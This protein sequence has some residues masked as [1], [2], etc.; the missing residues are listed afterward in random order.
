MEITKNLWHQALSLEQE[1]ERRGEGISWRKIQD[2]LCLGEKCA[3][4]LR[5]ALEN[6]SI[7]KARPDVFPV[8]TDDRVFHIC[9]VHI[10]FQDQLAVE[11]ALAYADEIN[12]TAIIINGDL[13]DFYKISRFVTNPA[14]QSVLSEIKQT[15]KFLEDLRYRFP[16]ARILYKQGNHEMRLEN[17]VFQQA[18]KIS[19]LISDLLIQQ[20]HLPQL[21]IEYMVEPFAY[22]KLWVLHGH[23]KPAGGNPEWICNVMWKYIHTHFIVAHFHRCQTKPFKDIAGHQYWTGACG[24]LA[25]KMD[26]AI[27]NQWQHGFADIRFADSGRFRAQISTIVDGEIY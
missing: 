1:H 18:D 22:G 6:K 15:R 9:D 10:P 8:D 26:Y 12:P 7:F 2:A 20:L 3:R 14:K 16:K 25:G 5:F 27:L 23:E 24:Y 17:Y 11:T 21:N 13:I 4:G 19:D